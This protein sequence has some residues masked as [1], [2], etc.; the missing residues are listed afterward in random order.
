MRV[1]MNTELIYL[2]DNNL[3]QVT[4]KLIKMETTEQGQYCIFDQSV[5]YPKGGGQACD[6]GTISN[7]SK[8]V[9]DISYT[10]FH[11]GQVLHYGDFK[12]FQFA[13]GSSW[14]LKIDPA[15][16]LTNSKGHTAGHLVHLVMEELVP[17]LTATKGHHFPKDAY[18][19]FDGL[20]NVDRDELILKAN[21]NIKKY[22]DEGF[23]V[24][25][26][27]LSLDQLKKLVKNIPFNLPEDKPLRTIAI[28]EYFPVPCGGTHLNDLSELKSAT[29]TKIK[30][31][32]GNTV[33]GYAFD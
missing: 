23:P 28:G 29:I 27:I 30:H 17:E 15:V 24:K 21:E 8:V 19:R 33:V 10:G 1:I 2:K 14:E 6:V 22:I 18:I 20:T 16:R 13:E 3:K 25:S 31:K 11:E 7:D 26:E 12:D 32:K 4:A 9:F 5:F